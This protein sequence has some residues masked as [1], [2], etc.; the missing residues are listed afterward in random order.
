MLQDQAFVGQ[1]RIAFVR[2]CRWPD[3]TKFV[4]IVS[5]REQPQPASGSEIDDCCPERRCGKCCIVGQEIDNRWG[6]AAQGP[7]GSR[8]CRAIWSNAVLGEPE[9]DDGCDE[10]KNG[11]YQRPCGRGGC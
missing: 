1:Q 7:R 10:Q 6:L 5:G 11:E 3:P 9:H 8:G 4:V 2:G